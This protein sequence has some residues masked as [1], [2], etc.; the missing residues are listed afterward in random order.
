MLELNKIVKKFPNFSL[1]ASFKVLQ[2]Q[3]LAL[4]GP[5]GSGKSTLLRIIAGLE[6]ADSGQVIWNGE[7]INQMPTER[8]NFGMV[9]QDYALFPHLNVEQNI[10]FGAVEARWPKDKVDSRVAALLKMVQLVPH[11]N[12]R[13]ALLSGGE[14]QRVAL[15]RAVATLPRLVLLDEPLGAL[16]QKLREELLMEIESVLED[17]QLPAI[18]VTHDQ[19]E[20]FQLADVVVLINEGKVVQIGSP[21]EVFQ[22]PANVWAAKFLGHKNIFSP[23][24]SV[25]VGLP[26]KSHLLPG[27]AVQLGGTE[28]AEVLE[29]RFLGSSVQLRIKWKGL[30]LIREVDSS[31]EYHPTKIG[32]SVDLSQC[33]ELESA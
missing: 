28:T 25:L 22:N 19:S 14:R 23:A 8:R 27:T 9:F 26:E 7:V 33:L 15:A 32:I 18:L 3:T 20:A 1:E 17:A 4:L 31:T 11:R 13:P 10:A 2:T 5:S 16:D 12:K 29:E 6:D 30:E 24:E 21:R